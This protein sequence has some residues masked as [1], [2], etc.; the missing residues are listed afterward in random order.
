MIR[1]IYKY[2]SEWKSSYRRKPL[3]LQGARQVGKTYAVKQFGKNDYKNIAYLN[4][5]QV[6]ELSKFFD[7]K[8]DPH[9]IIED[10]SLYLGKNITDDTLIF[11]DEIQIAPKAITSLKYFYEEAPE[12]HV[13][14]AGSLLGVSVGKESSFPVGKVN[15]MTMHPMSFSEY[16]LAIEEE[17]ALEKIMSNNLETSLPE[18]LHDKL[19]S[20]LK[21]YLF[22]GG[23]PEV[24]Q[25]YINNK[26]IVTVRKIQ[27]EILNSYQRDFSKYTSKIQAIKT[28]EVWNSIPY[29][30]AKE[31]K[32]FK[33]S[34]VKKKAR[35]SHYETTI[36]WLKKAGLVN[37]A[38][39]ISTPKLPISGYADRTKF[40]L[41]ALDTGLLG[42]MLNLSSDIITD[43]NKLFTE[44]NGAFIESFVAMEL[45][46][47]STDLF[48]WTSGNKAEIDFM[49]QKDETI[50]PIEVKSGKNLSMKSL[51]SYRH[52]YSNELSFR[53][54][55]LNF[56]KSKDGS[57]INIP[58]YASFLVIK[59]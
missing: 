58:L 29:Q 43:P 33:Y 23:M 31:S 41:Y 28:S 30:L 24:V 59:R 55:P 19:I 35:A 50:Y 44:Y 37:I 46:S 57:F 38:Y 8:L 36:E 13:I 48:Y 7:G 56:N 18:F 39:N 9:K 11:F 10:L 42:A 20:H 40:K 53:L 49:I 32:K 6:P 22:L 16:L 54:S 47:L 4:F 2:L 5:E 34:D 15:F 17:L 12:F 25:N 1:S 3:L 52:K 27:N 21:M 26:N 51:Q 45:S 14:A